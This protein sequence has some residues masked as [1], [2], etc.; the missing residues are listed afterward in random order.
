MTRLFRGWTHAFAN[1]TG[2]SFR[3]YRTQKSKS[4]PRKN[5]IG[6]SLEAYNQANNYMGTTASPLHT[7]RDDLQRSIEFASI[8]LRYQKEK[9]LVQVLRLFDQANEITKTGIIVAM[10]K[11]YHLSQGILEKF[12]SK[13]VE[14]EEIVRDMNA[15]NIAWMEIMKIT[16]EYSKTVKLHAGYIESKEEFDNFTQELMSR[17]VEFQT[18]CDENDETK[19]RSTL[20]LYSDAIQYLY[21]MYTENDAMRYEIISRQKIGQLTLN[22]T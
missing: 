1:P 6:N 11:M 22:D 12:H 18:A 20:S 8:E 4:N 5:P 10:E 2:N 7:T 14:D 3:F 17:K 9:S 13:K 15:I 21:A 19:K 16:E